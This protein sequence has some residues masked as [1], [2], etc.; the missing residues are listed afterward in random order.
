M[1]AANG[2]LQLDA[3][4]DEL[5]DDLAEREI[6]SRAVRML[7]YAPE[8]VAPAAALRDRVLAR[9]QQ[10]GHGASFE[11]NNNY[12]ARAAA[13]TWVE[14]APGIEV[15]ML[16]RDPATNAR[17]TLVRMGANLAFPAHEHDGIEDLYLIS[18]EAWVGDIPMSAGDYC[19]APAGTEHTDVRSGEAGAFSIVVSR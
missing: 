19:R 4:I 3:L 6:M 13:M 15:K 10:E 1:S 9:I 12:F 11:I 8:P 18:G 17:T 2:L 7:A 5:S 16:F 14:L